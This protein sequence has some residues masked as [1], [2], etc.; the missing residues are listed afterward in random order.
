MLSLIS[1]AIK[2]IHPIA[3]VGNFISKDACYPLNKAKEMALLITSYFEGSTATK[4]KYDAIAGNFDGM[5]MSFGIIQWNFGKGTLAPVLSDMISTDKNAFKACFGNTSDY[6]S[7]ISSLN[8][9]IETQKKWAVDQ[10]H[11]NPSEW[12]LPFKKIGQIKKFNDIQL[13]H[14]AIYHDHVMT[15]V[16][17]LRTLTPD[18]MQSIEL[19]SY[20]ALYD[21]CAAAILKLSS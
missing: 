17:W 15:C 13:K 8:S 10:Q 19:Q 1:W 2:H 4:L 21:M 18:L 20:C 7:L 9:S 14:A 12:M 11:K 6:E 5:G 3:L 16:N